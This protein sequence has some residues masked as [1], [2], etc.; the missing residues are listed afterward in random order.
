[1]AHVVLVHWDPGSTQERLE[2]LR[3]CGHRAA[4]F[5]P[6]GAPSLAGLAAAPPE[7]VVI[8]L[9]RLPSQGVAVA[10]AL[11]QRKGTRQVPLLFV[12]G[13]AEAVAR[14]RRTL[15]DVAWARWNGIGGAIKRAL[16]QERPAA[17]VVPGTMD[18]YSGTPL[19]KKLGIKPGSRLALLGAPQGFERSLV[20]LPDGVRIER[21]SIARCQVA[22]RFF[23]SARELEKGC[24]ALAARLPVGARLW[25]AWPKQSSGLATDLTQALVRERGLATGLV[26]FKIC[27][28]DATWS[29]LCFAH[30]ARRS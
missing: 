26:D 2:R 24:P 25:V 1:M 12:D 6:R 14:A 13:S 11:R 22:I 21:R 15:P 27:A 4:S 10:V 8:D 16:A 29:G 19:V 30:R 23:R 28:I 18:G 3:R 5:V 9:S 7:A 20:G 17:P